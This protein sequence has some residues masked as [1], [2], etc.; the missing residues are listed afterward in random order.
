MI[1][2]KFRNLYGIVSILFRTAICGLDGSKLIW[3]FTLA[4][5]EYV[6]LYY[7]YEI[8]FIMLGFHIDFQFFMQNRAIPYKFP[9]FYMKR[10]FID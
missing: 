1:R 6:K 2:Y 7:G 5:L 8:R 4:K 3:N 10:G 9:I